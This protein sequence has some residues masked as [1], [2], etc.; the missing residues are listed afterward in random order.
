L[1]EEH[2][3]YIDEINNSKEL[4]DELTAKLIAAMNDYK[5]TKAEKNQI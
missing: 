1:K 5:K 2:N 3:D 4:N